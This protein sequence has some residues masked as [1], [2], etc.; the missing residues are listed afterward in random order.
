MRSACT[1][2]ALLL[3]AAATA[4]AQENAA[5][6]GPLFMLA[7]AG[8]ARAPVVVEAA[9]VA[10][11]RRRVRLSLEGVQL[12]DALAQIARAAGLQVVFAD[13]VVPVTARVHLQAEEI[14]VAAALT[15]VLLDARVDVVLLPGGSVVLV[16]RGTWATG[17][18]A[19]RVTDAR[20]G[21]GV[22]GAR[23][24]LQGTSLGTV[25][26]DSGG[27]RIANV[28]P[29][30]YVVT[31]RRIGYV[32]GTKA[33]TVAAD[34]EVAVDIRLEISASPLDAVVVTGTI[35][36]TEQKAL[37]NPISII[38]A[39]MIQER[40]ITKVSDLFRGDIPGV[41][42]A[43]YGAASH[44][45]GAPVY[46][47]GTTELFDAPTLK[48]YVDGVEIANS[49]YLNELDPTM[50]DH[51]EIIRGPEASTLYGAQAI[52]GV[53]QVFTKKGSLDTPPRLTASVGA[54][55]MEGSFGSGVSQEDNVSVA[56]GTR[57][58][59]YNLGAS[60]RREGSW[61]PGHYINTYSSYGSLS[62]RP[63]NSPLQ[64]D[65][66]ARLGEQ[67]GRAAG[68]EATARAVMDGSLRFLGNGLPIQNIF[69]IP[70]QGFGVTARYVRAGWQQMLTVGTDRGANGNDAAVVAPT[71][72]SPS[73]SFTAVYANQT[74]RLTAAYNSAW[75][76]RLSDRL[77]ANVVAGADYWS[78]Q[79]DGY[80]D[81]Q[82]TSTEGQLGNSNVYVSR[83]RDHS[84]GVFGQARLGVSD[85]LFFTAGARV[86]E[87]PALPMPARSL[88]LSGPRL[89][90]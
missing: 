62:F 38:T 73:D 82:T 45:Y 5:P 8:P 69:T 22:P 11:L 77:S 65:V 9:S 68:N 41:F 55:R 40:G 23:V 56:G 24:S 67:T 51:I 31:V 72:S 81:Y 64:L 26:N 44:F 17:S 87:G 74:A 52:N 25:T 4:G 50:I 18:V 47:R 90:E 30:S 3:A 19:G 13:G 2:F 35:A 28:P 70:Q 16:K 37:A 59:S 60:Y 33:V 21:H 53:M 89:N 88:A 36:P 29:G 83:Q 10:A 12:T 61:T 43:D 27:F 48:T 86:D 57:E 34:Q 7:S 6:R 46:V 32:P 79:R 49:Q 42:T 54:G 1:A 15:D 78:F 63:A 75:D 80:T 58:A 66:T 84:T 14:T 76:V 39:S 85:A 71:Y 20:T